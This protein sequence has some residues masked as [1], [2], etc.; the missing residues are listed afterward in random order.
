[1]KEYEIGEIIA[2]NRG[3]E[4]VIDV[5][6]RGLCTS[7]LIIPKEIFIECYKKWILQS[8]ELVINITGDAR[9]NNVWS[10][11]LLRD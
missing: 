7:E 10:R 5:G 9:A 1:M 3:I 2:T 4:R 8:D 6:D 11:P